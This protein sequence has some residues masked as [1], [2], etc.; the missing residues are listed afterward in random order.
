[1]NSTR[2]TRPPF[3]CACHSTILHAEQVM[4]GTRVVRVCRHFVTAQIIMQNIQYITGKC[5]RSHK[6]PINCGVEIDSIDNKQMPIFGA[7]SHN[8]CA[9]R[10]KRYNYLSCVMW[11]EVQLTGQGFCSLTDAVT[12]CGKWP[13]VPDSQHSGSAATS[14]QLNNHRQRAIVHTSQRSSS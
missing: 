11:R 13:W 6:W 7:I 14:H 1:M 5:T 2:R 9:N 8:V 10:P 3:N 4:I 12:R